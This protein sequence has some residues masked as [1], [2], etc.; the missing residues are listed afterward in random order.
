M[1]KL[2]NLSASERNALLFTLQSTRTHLEKRRAGVS[3]QLR[4]LADQLAAIDRQLDDVE[5][6]E[7]YLEGLR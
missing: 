3:R 6:S 5:Q 1:S 2:C 4:A 7:Q